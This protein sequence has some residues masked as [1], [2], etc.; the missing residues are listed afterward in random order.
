MKFAFQILIMKNTYL[1]KRVIEKVEIII[2]QSY[3]V[4]VK[5]TVKS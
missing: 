2:Y 3:I 5:I 1:Y 4:K